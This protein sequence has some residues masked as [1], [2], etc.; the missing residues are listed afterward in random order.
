LLPYN[1][2][3][4]KYTIKTAQKQRYFP[5]TRYSSRRDAEARRIFTTEGNSEVL[6]GHGGKNQIAKQDTKRVLFFRWIYAI[7]KITLTDGRQIWII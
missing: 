4:A 5:F 7:I 6:G 3:L 1:S 2:L